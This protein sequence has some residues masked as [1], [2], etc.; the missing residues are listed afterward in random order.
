MLWPILATLTLGALSLGVYVERSVS[1]DLLATTD[2]ELT[3][4][5]IVRVTGGV[6]GPG[7]PQPDRPGG[8][9]ETPIDGGPQDEGDQNTV[10]VQLVV[11]DQGE[12]LEIVSPDGVSPFSQEQLIELADTETIETIGGEPRYRVRTAIGRDG[13]TLIVALSLDQ[14]DSSLAS[15]RRNLIIGGLGLVVAQAVVVWL[16][17]GAVA[18]PVTRMSEVAHRIA[19]GEFDSDV[20]K[21]QG[22]QETANL[23]TDLGKMLTRL[24]ETI[25]VQEAAA[26]EA[27]KAKTDMER[28]IADASHELRTPLTALKG[29]SDLYHNDM[30]DQD[31]LK[32]AMDRIGSESERLTRLVVDLLKLV[33]TSEVEE[34]VDVAAIV[35]A[36]GH[37]LKAANPGRV[38]G[39]HLPRDGNGITAATVTGDPNRLHQAVL[40]LAAN[41]C[42]H[43]PDSTPIELAVTADERAVVISVVDHGPGLDQEQADRLF[44]P[45]TRGDESRSRLSHDGAGLGLALVNQIVEQHEGTVSVTETPGGGATFAVTVPRTELPEQNQTK[46]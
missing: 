10:P 23:A 6:G 34:A 45:F 26:E 19:S 44:L 9:G 32:R 41:A 25:E 13:N 24:R 43:T 35:S 21:P 27:T 28:F 22:P 37:D 16:I 30:L 40:N 42:H 2:D 20:G 15:L 36:V 8:P 18:R 3:R 5:L 29:Y 46:L 1:A 33:R 11:D 14:I 17:A 12:L 39:V 38:I 4:A 31:G 7:R